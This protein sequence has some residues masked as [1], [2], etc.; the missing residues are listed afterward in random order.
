[1]T[2]KNVDISSYVSKMK[3]QRKVEF[4]RR[5]S[6]RVYWMLVGAGLISLFNY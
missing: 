2:L 1:M 6:Y 4:W 5:M 3:H